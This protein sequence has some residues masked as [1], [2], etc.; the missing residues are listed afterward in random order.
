MCPVILV[1]KR[2][3]YDLQSSTEGIAWNLEKGMGVLLPDSVSAQVEFLKEI[4]A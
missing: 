2:Q 1:S 4:K 3:S